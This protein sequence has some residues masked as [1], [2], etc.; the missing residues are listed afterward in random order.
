[1]VRIVFFGRLSDASENLDTE[2]PSG[3]ENTEA[4][5]V[6]LAEGN[7]R[8][9]EAMARPGIRVIVN[10]EVRHGPAS[11]ADGDEIA[12]MSPVGGG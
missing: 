9:A 2:L 11:V 4:L 5:A 6:W 8:L 10:D 1:M 7:E 3:V 12:F